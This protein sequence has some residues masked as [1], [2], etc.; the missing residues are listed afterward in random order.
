MS[1]RR[2][3]EVGCRENRAGVGLVIVISNQ[4]DILQFKD[5]K[6]NSIRYLSKVLTFLQCRQQ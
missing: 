5:V 2:L 3:G 1:M 6:T 4:K